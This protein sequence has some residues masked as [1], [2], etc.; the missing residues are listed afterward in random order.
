MQIKRLKEYNNR[1]ASLHQYLLTR[2][3]YSASTITS[4][5]NTK[6][7]NPHGH[8]RVR[9]TIFISGTKLAIVIAFGLYIPS[10]CSG[11]RKVVSGKARDLVG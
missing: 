3:I 8:R 6:Y 4:G 11:V 10:A 9:T 1:G 2:P 5:S 7:I